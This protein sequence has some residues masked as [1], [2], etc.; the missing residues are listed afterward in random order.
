MEWFKDVKCFLITKTE[1]II[2]MPQIFFIWRVCACV[3]PSWKQKGTNNL[4]HNMEEKQQT[5]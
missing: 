3:W 2:F 4:W 1:Q 5:Q